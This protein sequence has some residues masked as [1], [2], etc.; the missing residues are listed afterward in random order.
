MWPWISVAAFVKMAGDSCSFAQ[1]CLVNKKTCYCSNR[2]ASLISCDFMFFL[3]EEILYYT[4]IA[5][6]FPFMAT[7]R[8]GQQF[9][10]TNMLKLPLPEKS[11]M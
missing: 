7:L 2:Y 8:V 10:L 4:V 1:I 9:K 5:Q 3:F 11:I 6:L